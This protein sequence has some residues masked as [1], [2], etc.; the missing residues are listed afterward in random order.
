MGK[1][2][3]RVKDGEWIAPK[4]QGYQLACCDCGLTHTLNFEIENGKIIF[5]AFRDNRATAQVRRWKRKGAAGDAAD[6]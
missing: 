4:M 6:N 2:H 5:Q 1:K 3:L